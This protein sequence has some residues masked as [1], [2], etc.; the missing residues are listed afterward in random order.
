MRMEFK[1]SGRGK[2]PVDRFGNLRGDPNQNIGVP[3]RRHAKGR[4]RSYFDPNVANVISDGRQPGSLGQ[5]EEWPFHR[6]PLVTDWNVGKCRG[7]QVRLDVTPQRSALGHGARR[8]GLFSCAGIQ[9]A[10]VTIAPL[11]VFL[12]LRIAPRW[13]G[14]AFLWN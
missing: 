10:G 5:A 13:T 2:V 1:G 3:D 12:Y 4:V 11:S 6:V 8:F 9:R 14:E 7:E